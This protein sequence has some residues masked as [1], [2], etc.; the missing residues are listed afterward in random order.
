MASERV[1]S[2]ETGK[3]RGSLNQL[4]NLFTSLQGVKS[5]LETYDKVCNDIANAEKSLRD[6]RSAV[7]DLD[8]KLLELSNSLEDKKK[9][10]E[11]EV[12]SVAST[13]KAEYAEE[14]RGIRDTL[15]RLR[16]EEASTQA[17]LTAL[18][19]RVVRE[20][21]QLEATK[22]GIRKEITELEN[23]RILLKEALNKTAE[24]L[25]SD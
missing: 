25:G 11:E 5:L 23:K 18:S 17:T 9:E 2:E 19:N 3:A 13:K 12:A 8:S 14:I 1:S 20:T 4:I 22:E 21:S 10:V 24:A 6:K 7:R 15:N 16:Q